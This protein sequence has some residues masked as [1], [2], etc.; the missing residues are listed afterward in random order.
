MSC[1]MFHLGFSYGQRSL[2][3]GNATV[4][5]ADMVLAPPP[6]CLIMCAGAVIMR[7]SWM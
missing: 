6:L 4:I 3:G 5:V 7:R 2:P 1:C